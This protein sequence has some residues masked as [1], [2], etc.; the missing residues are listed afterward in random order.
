MW[1]ELRLIV[2]SHTRV[3]FSTGCLN[4]CFYPLSPRAAVPIDRARATR[5]WTAM[6]RLTALMRGGCTVSARASANGALANAF[7]TREPRLTPHRRSLAPRLLGLPDHQQGQWNAVH[8]V[9]LVAD[10]RP[11]RNPVPLDFKVAE[12]LAHWS[13][14]PGDEHFVVFIDHV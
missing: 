13:A 3:R 4:T 10:P 2:V 5:C 9:D 12:G 8:S 7:G 14:D 6:D 11:R 1:S